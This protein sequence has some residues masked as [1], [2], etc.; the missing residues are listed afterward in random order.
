MNV[1]K[2]MPMDEELRELIAKAKARWDAMTTEQR[3]AEME[4]QKASWIRAELGFGSDADEAEYRRRMEDGEPLF[5]TPLG[6]P[7]R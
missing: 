2:P 4:A 5:D 1:T 7:S 3:V 6:A